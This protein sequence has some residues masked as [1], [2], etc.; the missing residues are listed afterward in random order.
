MHTMGSAERTLVYT[1]QYVLAYGRSM[2]RERNEL[3]KHKSVKCQDFSLQYNLFTM[4]LKMCLSEHFK[5][6]LGQLFVLF[7]PSTYQV[8][9]WLKWKATVNVATTK[10]ECNN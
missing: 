8:K 6:L 1:M 4:F 10:L 2:N 7:N 9:C 5:F 3:V